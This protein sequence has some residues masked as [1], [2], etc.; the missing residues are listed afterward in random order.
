MVVAA[1]K[2]W[3]FQELGLGFKE[4]NFEVRALP[5]QGEPPNYSTDD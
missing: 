3:G 2:L 5:R 1:G 4:L